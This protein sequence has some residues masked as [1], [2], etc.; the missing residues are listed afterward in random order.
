MEE[1][2]ALKKSYQELRKRAFTE[3]FNS[4][5]N[6]IDSSFESEV[7]SKCN[8][9]RN[10]LLDFCVT[11]GEDVQELKQF[12]ISVED[13]LLSSNTSAFYGS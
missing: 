1:Y 9:I 4:L 6:N 11:N 5:A 8:E 3:Q 7:N 2:K 13:E 10:K 12:F